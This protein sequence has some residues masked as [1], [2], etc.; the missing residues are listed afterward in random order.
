MRRIT[1]ALA[2]FAASFAAAPATHAETAR[3]YAVPKHPR[4]VAAPNRTAQPARR[5]QRRS[6]PTAAP[7]VPHPPSTPVYLYR[8]PVYGTGRVH[9]G[10]YGGFDR[11]G[12]VLPQTRNDVNVDVDVDAGTA[13]PRGGGT[14]VLT[15]PEGNGASE[16]IARLRAEN[17]RLRR[18]LAPD[19]DALG[20]AA[21]AE[22]RGG[23]ELRE[24][25]GAIVARR[26]RQ[27][28]EQ[29]SG[30]RVVTVEPYQRELDTERTAIRKLERRERNPH[31]L[32][33]GFDD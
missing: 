13:G 14:V 10:F 6:G 24:L 12:E 31:I 28:Q 17:W 25:I 18:S 20:L 19:L 3:S 33:L 32:Y 22:G 23:A 9:P 1:L 16:E 21:T 8:D 15:Q 11:Y 5:T 30:A 26:D 29:V 27:W 4:T 2:A 7:G